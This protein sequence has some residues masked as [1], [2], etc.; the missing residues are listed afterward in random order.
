[1][2]RP[3]ANIELGGTTL[4]D[5]AAGILRSVGCDPVV[6]A[7]A[8]DEGPLA[9]LA[10]ALGQ[11]KTFDVFVL[12]CDLPLAGPAI[13]RLAQLPAGAAVAIDPDEREQPLCSRWPRAVALEAAKRLVD[14]GE[15]RMSALLDAID[16][17]FVPATADELLN[18]NTAEDLARA[19]ALL[20]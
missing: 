12:A 1:M 4:V 16:P 7:D 6:I 2:G 14:S 15:R 19:A 18:V 9:A 20:R 17:E 10:D 5:R 11:L 13:A 8:G 3:K